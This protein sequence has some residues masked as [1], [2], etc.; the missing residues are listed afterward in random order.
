MEIY[1]SVFGHT[2]SKHQFL[3]SLFKKKHS[4]DQMITE[5]HSLPLIVNVFVIKKKKK[6]KTYT[7]SS[8]SK[9]TK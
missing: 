6:L 3:T 4:L 1:I 7:L 8:K 9:S 5:L 2:I